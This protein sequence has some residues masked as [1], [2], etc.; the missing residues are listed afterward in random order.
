M[1]QRPIP[2]R[3]A[4]YRATPRRTVHRN[5]PYHNVPSRNGPYRNAPHHI[6]HCTASRTTTFHAATPHTATYCTVTSMPQRPIHCSHRTATATP[7]TAT[8]HRGMGCGVA[9][10]LAPYRRL[11]PRLQSLVMSDRLGEDMVEKRR[12]R[13]GILQC[14]MGIWQVFR[15]GLWG[16]VVFCV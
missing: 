1:P 3:N 10:W 7:R 14:R 12:K 6:M 4:P 11:L 13:N 15:P 5:V 8:R 2:R 16:T 9:V